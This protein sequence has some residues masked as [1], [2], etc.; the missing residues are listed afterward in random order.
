MFTGGEGRS[1]FSAQHEAPQ[2]CLLLAHSSSVSRPTY[3]KST[4]ISSSRFKF[5]CI[6]GAL[7]VDMRD[8]SLST[9]VAKIRVANGSRS[10]TSTFPTQSHSGSVA[11]T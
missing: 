4:C 3:A 6:S 11:W 9:T 8:V 10:Q 2:S 7:L 5:T 1:L